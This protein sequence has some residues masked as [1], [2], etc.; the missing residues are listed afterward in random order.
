IMLQ[1][2]VF[3]SFT[4][5]DLRSGGPFVLSQ[6]VG[7]MPA[8][9]FLF[10]TGVTLAFLMDGGERKGVPAG[11]RV[12]TVLRRAGYLFLLAFAFRFQLWLFGWPV[13]PWTDLLKVDVLNCMGFSIALLSV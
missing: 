13:S 5:T 10:L 6:F 3:D 12:L 9:I 4:R 1:G 7:G 2:H 8:G 11:M